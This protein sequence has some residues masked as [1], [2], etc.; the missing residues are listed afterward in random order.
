MY[1]LG[2]AIHRTPELSKGKFEE[3]NYVCP[4]HLPNT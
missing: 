3:E 4:R 2:M 1:P